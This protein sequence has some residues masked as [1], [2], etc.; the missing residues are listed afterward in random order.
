[1]E[2]SLVQ[3][4]DMKRAAADAA[5]QL[6]MA[7]GRE[8]PLGVGSGSTVA[9]FVERMAHAGYAPAVAVAASNATRALLRAA[10]IDVVTLG[11]IGELTLYVDG[12][13]EI[14]PVGRMIKGGGGAH[15]MEKI[16]ASA[17]D[18]FVCI[19]DESKRVQHLGCHAPVPLEVVPDAESLVVQSIAALGGCATKRLGATSDVGNLLLDATGMDL[20]DP[21]HMETL[22]DSLPGV[23]EC[24]IFA[25][26]RADVAL[27]GTRDGG[28][29]RIDF[30]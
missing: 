27:V 17:S 20:R 28:V 16:L 29:L 10:G 15:T 26:R 2:I 22:L 24:G 3:A 13:D 30:D 8:R 5:V 7:E 1:M 11:E 14:D 12:A 9:I 18:R 6:I 19:V 25:H 4:E 21:A 23:V